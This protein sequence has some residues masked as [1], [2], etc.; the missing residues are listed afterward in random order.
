MEIWY[1]CVDAPLPKIHC[2]TV[3][4]VRTNARYLVF[5]SFCTLSL[6]KAI[7]LIIYVLITII[8]LM[9]FCE[10]KCQLYF[11]FLKKED[12]NWP[13]LYKLNYVQV[14]KIK[15][16]HHIISILLGVLAFL[17]LMVLFLFHHQAIVRLHI[18]V[19]LLAV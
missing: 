6:Y 7:F 15:I 13:L 2:T 17:H 18:P 4:I 8:Q 9:Q 16:S 19:P 3:E 5:C 11:L 12:I 1:H 14:I 10:R